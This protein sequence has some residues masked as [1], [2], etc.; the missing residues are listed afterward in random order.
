MQL[1][2]DF[3][4]GLLGAVAVMSPEEVLRSWQVSCGRTKSPAWRL[5]HSE[6]TRVVFMRSS[7]SLLFPS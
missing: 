5:D 7:A 4:V 1:A 3:S 6:H 2:A